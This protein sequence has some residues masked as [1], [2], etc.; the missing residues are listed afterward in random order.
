MNDFPF[1]SDTPWIAAKGLGF[2]Y[3]ARNVL[4]G[5]DLDLRPG[6]HYIVA[7]PNGAGKSTLLDLLANLKRPAGGTLSIMGR[8]VGAYEPG[9]LARTLALAPQ[10]YRLDF[11]FT[12]RE[13]VAMGRRPFLGRWGVMDEE[14][15]RIVDAALADLRLGELAGR[16]VTALSGGERRRC[17]VARALAQTTPV[18]LLDEPAAGLD[19]AQAMSL[20]AVAR[21]LAERGR[22]VVTVGHDLNLAAMFGHEII[23]LRDGRLVAQGPVGDVFTGENIST[24]YDTPARVRRDDFS[25]ALSVSFRVHTL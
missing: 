22:L 4:E 15:H 7:G 13:V 17:V 8:P 6:R 23:F 3:G 20:M 1:G 2:A 18:V 16:T 19:I 10:E 12:V 9:G 5:V 11:S 21:E 14:D 25:G 24:I